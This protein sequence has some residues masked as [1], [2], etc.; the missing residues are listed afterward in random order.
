L[1]QE[2]G[3]IVSFIK[4]MLKAQRDFWKEFKENWKVCLFL[5][6]VTIVMSEYL[7]VGT[8]E[9]FISFVFGLMVA[10]IIGLIY[11]GIYQSVSWI[12]NKLNKFK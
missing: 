4:G 7:N 5:Y 1:L 9:I 6:I 12:K 11:M 3:L 2:G 10:T 8:I